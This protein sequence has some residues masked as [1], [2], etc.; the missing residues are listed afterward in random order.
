MASRHDGPASPQFEPL[1]FRG[2][3]P[4]NGLQKAEVSQTLRD[5]IVAA[6]RGLR[7]EPANVRVF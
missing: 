1:L 7:V 2:G 3:T 4:W 5:A 6:P